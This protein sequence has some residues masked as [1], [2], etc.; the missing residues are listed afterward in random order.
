MRLSSV[1]LQRREIAFPPFYG[2]QID[3]LQQR[4]E[5]ARG[6]LF[7]SRLFERKG[8]GACL[9]ALGPQ[10]KSIAIPVQDLHPVGGSNEILHTDWVSWLSSTVG[11][12]C[13]AR[14]CAYFDE[15]CMAV[16][17][18][19]TWKRAE[20]YRESCRRGWSTAQSVEE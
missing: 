2:P 10:R 16:W 3:A 14:N 15:Q 13:T 6:D 4:S 1:L 18:W 20:P 9:Q 8:V 5:F 19:F 12:L 7:T 11:I 17:Q